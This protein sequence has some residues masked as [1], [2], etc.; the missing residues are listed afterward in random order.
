MV[1]VPSGMVKTWILPGPGPRP[2][3]HQAEMM[4]KGWIQGGGWGGDRND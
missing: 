1:L 4:R 2:R 3:E